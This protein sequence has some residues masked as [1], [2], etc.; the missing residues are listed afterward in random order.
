MTISVDLDGDNRRRDGLALVT[1]SGPQLKRVEVDLPFRSLF[2]SLGPPDPTAL[3]LL[4]IAGACYVIDKATARKSAPDAWTRDLQV[5]FPVS[6]PKRW[7]KVGARL[8]TALTFLSGDV[9]RTS[10]RQSSCKLFVAPKMRR[11][12]AP[13]PGE[14]D[15][16]DAVTLF[17]GGLDSLIGTIDYLRQNMGGRL[18][19]VGP[20]DAPGPKIQQQGQYE[21]KRARF[22]RRAKLVQVPV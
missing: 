21:H 12:K 19:L 13:V 8:D 17:S 9:W 14:L 11:K 5:S 10:F 16:F 7:K 20:Y 18:I 15:T 4:M 1:L 3:D 2:S 6:D 22:T